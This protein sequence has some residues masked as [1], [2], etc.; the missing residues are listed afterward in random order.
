MK[1]NTMIY[2]T[3]TELE[4]TDLEMVS[5]GVVI[6]AAEEVLDSASNVLDEAKNVAKKI[7]DYFSDLF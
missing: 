1:N 5:G 2:N 6:E 4:L 7:W 3:S